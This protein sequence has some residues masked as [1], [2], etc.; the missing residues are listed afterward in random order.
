MLR[1]ASA[2]NRRAIRDGRVELYV[3]S[4]SKL[5]RGIEP[6]DKIAVRQ[7]SGDKLL[8]ILESARRSTEPALRP[9]E[10]GGLIA[11]ALQPRTPGATEETSRNAGRHIL[12]AL[13]EAGFNR[14]RLEVKA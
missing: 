14:V 9:C 12:A 3:A 8:P 10:A 2:R 7:D 6:F 13:T 1:Q 4:G 5:P 11:V